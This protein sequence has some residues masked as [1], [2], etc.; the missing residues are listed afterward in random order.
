MKK[1]ACASAAKEGHLHILVWLREK[2]CSIDQRT[3]DFA[4]KYQRW[5]VLDWLEIQ[6]KK[7]VRV[8]KELK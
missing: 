5:N 8:S 7:D 4:K 2:G 6:G 1:G 3:Y